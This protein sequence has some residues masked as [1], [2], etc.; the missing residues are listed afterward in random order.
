MA[1]NKMT[2]FVIT[3]VLLDCLVIPFILGAFYP[4]YSHMKMVLS[5]LGA[6]KSPVRLVYNFWMACLGIGF[7]IIGFKLFASYKSTWYI[8][9]ML[10]LMVTISYAILDCLVSSI[11]SVGDSKEML[12]LAEKLHG[13]GSAIGCTLF[14]LGG[15]FATMLLWKNHPLA[16]R[17]LLICWLMA[18]LTFGAFVS[19][20]NVTQSVSGI[21]KLLIY[22][23][24]WQRLSFLLMYI[25]YIVLSLL[26][27]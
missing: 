10:L 23:G 22:N 16:A 14:V 19:G 6:K 21:K 3:L 5:V 20:D 25:P 2:Q 26:K 13:Y 11:F 27:E 17:W 12:T 15:L 18:I 8:P 24:L 9:S 7:I 1:I 4:K